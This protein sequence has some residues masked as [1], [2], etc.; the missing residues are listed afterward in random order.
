MKFII[1]FWLFLLSRS[2]LLAWSGAGHMVIAAEAFRELTP[3][4][5]TKVTMILKAHPNYRK[6]E[7]SYAKAASE[8][9]HDTF[10]FMR[11]STWPDEI[12]RGAGGEKQ[13]DHP[14]WHYIDYPLTPPNFP[15]E[16]APSPS[17]DVLYG[18]K[19]C[20]TKLSDP[21]T[22]AVE[23]AVYLSYL[24]HLVGDMHQP[25]HCCSLVNETYPKGDKG[26]NDFYITAGAKGIKLHALW[27]G[28]LG[29]RT[30]PQTQLN[31]AIRLVLEYPRKNLVELK[32]DETPKSW[33]LE[34]RQLAI[35]NA[36]LKGELK[37]STMAENAPALPEGYTKEAKMVAEKQAALAGYRL[38]D[39][40]GKWM[41]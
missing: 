9:D 28:L 2:Q 38:A 22:S 40:I 30:H 41:R 31:Y 25:L 27:D 7:E 3:E 19:Q 37:G 21:N 36:Y 26:G 1:V 13:Y 34:G 6:W 14:H 10:I 39:E 5:K 24:I 17:D 32:K 8:I 29:T 35:D 16:P 15:M 20:E 18:V 4:L 23:R 11:A 33:S 12:R